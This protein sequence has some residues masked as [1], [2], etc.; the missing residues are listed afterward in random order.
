LSSK[1]HL[2]PL[3][4][5]VLF[6]TITA[7]NLA[8]SKAKE[9]ERL[10][11]SGS[12]STHQSFSNFYALYFFLSLQS[13][14]S[15]FKILSYNFLFLGVKSESEAKLSSFNRECLALGFEEELWQSM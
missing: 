3:G 10:S 4:F 8:V 15:L 1:F 14:I 12:L 7:N 5:C 9:D 11:I 13:A 6:P 2:L